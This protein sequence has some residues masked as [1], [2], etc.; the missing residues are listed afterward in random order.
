[1]TNLTDA[2]REEITNVKKQHEKQMN[3][4]QV[5]LAKSREELKELKEKVDGL[6]KNKNTEEQVDLELRV[7]SQASYSWL[8]NKRGVWIKRGGWKKLKFN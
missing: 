1:M 3:L 2:L 4:V 7:S 5:E 8:R 6:A